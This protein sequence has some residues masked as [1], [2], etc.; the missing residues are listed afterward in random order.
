MQKPFEKERMKLTWQ[1]ITLILLLLLPFTGKAQGNRNNIDARKRAV[2]YFHLEAVS[3]QEQ[4]RYD[5]AYEL[6]EYCL[7]LDPTSATTKY[8]LAA[9][10]TVLGKDSTACSLLES[11]VKENP[12]NEDY[13]DALVNQYARLGNWKAAIAVYERI[14]ETAHSKE[15]IYKALYTLYYNDDSYE[16]ALGMLDRIEE[17]EGKRRELTT[18]RLQIYMH[19]NRYEEMIAIIKQEIA[20]NPDDFRF[21]VLLGDVYGMMGEFA[22]AEEIYLG[23]LEA[24][25]DDVLAQ[26][27]LAELYAVVEKDQAFS[28]TMETLIKNEKLETQERLKYLVD[29][30]LYKETTDS[31]Y[32]LEFYQQLLQLPF[33]RLELHQSYADYLEYKKAD[34]SRLIPVYEKIVELDAENIEAIIKLLQNAIAEDDKEAVFKYA[35]EALMFLPQHLELHFYKGLSSSMMGNV[36]ESIGIYLEGLE[37]RDAETDPSVVAAVFTIVGDTYHEL[38]LME[39]AYVAYDSALVYEPDKIDVL[40]NYSYFLSIENRELQKALEMSH[41]TITAEPDNQ[42]YLDTYAWILFK[43]KRYE[44]AKAYAEKII[45]LDEEISPVVLHHIG[46]IFAKCGDNESAVIYW[47]RALDAGDEETELLKKKI[48]KRK[49]YNGAKH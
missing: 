42:T 49:Y 4:E 30:V 41:K 3:L 5:E 2:D 12:D 39:E 7:Q 25:P 18:K 6:F 1:C 10:Y 43:L 45:S 48:K 16:K 11:I 24:I 27:A 15:E 9:Y 38:G 14:V 26:S 28:N 22:Q 29:Y 46:D 32:V 40:N 8:L 37:K 44:E 23:V 13:N 35:D 47:Q 17:F 33:D 21:R 36:K 31:A 20:E 34:K 19:L